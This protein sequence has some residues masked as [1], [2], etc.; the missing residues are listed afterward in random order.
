MCI[1]TGDV[2][3]DTTVTDHHCIACDYTNT[4]RA[5]ELTPSETMNGFYDSDGIR[6]TYRIYMYVN[7]KILVSKLTCTCTYH[8]MMLYQFQLK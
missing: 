3:C 4:F 1:S 8:W 2:V 5:I 7:I 6:Y